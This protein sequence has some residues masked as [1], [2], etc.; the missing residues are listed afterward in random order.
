[1]LQNLLH[2]S[3]LSENKRSRAKVYTILLEFF[4]ITYA[5]LGFR[6]P[7][8]ITLPSANIIPLQKAFYTLTFKNCRP[9]VSRT[10]L[11]HSTLI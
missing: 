3:C 7:W 1:M 2:V 5:L 9:L 10:K 4:V 8:L 11:H 6:L